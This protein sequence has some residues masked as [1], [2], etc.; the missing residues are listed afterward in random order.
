MGLAMINYSDIARQAN[1]GRELLREFTSAA[2]PAA[3]RRQGLDRKEQTREE[4]LRLVR[5]VFFTGAAIPQVVIFSAVEHGSGCS[6]VCTRVAETLSAEVDG[7]VCVVD[8]DLRSPA[9]HHYFEIEPS[10]SHANGEF[11][12]AP[13]R[14]TQSR[15]SRSNLW[16]LPGVSA[17]TDPQSPQG[18]ERLRSRLVELRREFAYV[19]IDAPPVNAYADATLLGEVSDG[20]VMVLKAND[21]RREAAMRAKETL[22]KAAVPLLGAVLNERTY[23]IPERLYRK[24]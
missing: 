24:L 20:V 23:P 12:A 22:S 17:R 7:L 21:T 3:T 16:L 19:L 1:R 5:R 10:V 4:I 13:V 14:R 15:L 6:W 11:R 18:F 9:L 8:A 2:V